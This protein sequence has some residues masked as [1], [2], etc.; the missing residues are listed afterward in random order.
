MERAV[1]Y[2]I[3]AG[4]IGFGAWIFIAGLSSRRQAFMACVAVIPIAIGLLSAFGDDLGIH[5]G[6]SPAGDD[7]GG[8]GKLACARPFGSRNQLKAFSACRSGGR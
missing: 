8:F 6:R 1:A 2:V 3:S 4:I 5:R 7:Q